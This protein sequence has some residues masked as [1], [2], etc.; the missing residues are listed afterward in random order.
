[1]PALSLSW[2]PLLWGQMFLEAIPDPYRVAVK[3]LYV[4]G[5]PTVTLGNTAQIDSA[6]VKV[7]A[8]TIHG[9]AGRTFNGRVASNGFRR[10]RFG[11]SG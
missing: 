2:A 9:A 1:M 8:E 11:N 7:A 5:E 6:P 10:H 3:W 4:L